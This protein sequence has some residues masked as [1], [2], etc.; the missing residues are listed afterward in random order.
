MFFTFLNVPLSDTFPFSPQ[1]PI[2]LTPRAPHDHIVSPCLWAPALRPRL[3]GITSIRWLQ[4]GARSLGMP[5]SQK[6]GLTTAGHRLQ[7]LISSVQGSGIT[8]LS[9]LLGE[10]LLWRMATV[11]TGRPVMFPPCQQPSTGQ[12][13]GPCGAGCRM[14]R[15]YSREVMRAPTH[16]GSMWRCENCKTPLPV[17]F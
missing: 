14:D 12:D 17:H 16:T 3:P 6:P 13:R 5:A 8:F 11:R 15:S 7:N 9:F 1:P 2:S 4:P 10:W